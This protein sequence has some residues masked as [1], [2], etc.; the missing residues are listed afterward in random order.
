MFLSYESTDRKRHKR[1]GKFGKD[2]SKSPFTVSPRNYSA[3]PGF[4]SM[5]LLW[6]QTSPQSKNFH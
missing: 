2:S 6:T 4:V 3:A 5:G 1:R